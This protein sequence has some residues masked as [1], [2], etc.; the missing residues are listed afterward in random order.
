[1]QPCIL[2][3]V[4]PAWLVCLPSSPL[5]T[6]RGLGQRSTRALMDARQ[7]WLGPAVRLLT[8]ACLLHS[9]AGPGAGQNL[10]TQAD[11]DHRLCRPCRLPRQAGRRPG[12]RQRAL[13]RQRGACLG[14][15][16]GT[17]LA[18][19]TRSAGHPT[20]ASA[21]LASHPC[22]ACRLPCPLAGCACDRLGV[23]VRLLCCRLRLQPPRH[24]E[25]VQR[26]PVRPVQ[27]PGQRGRLWCA[28]V[29][30]AE[31]EGCEVPARALSRGMVQH[32]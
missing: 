22:F 4:L 10:D 2:S 25:A 9:P 14:T 20:L 15:A 13:A 18:S 28:R 6:A 12:L 21:A 31:G 7:P 30:A 1:M 24:F 11:A 3:S 27:R 29:P 32:T 8:P 19:R 23:A 26:H 17:C 16:P 5:P